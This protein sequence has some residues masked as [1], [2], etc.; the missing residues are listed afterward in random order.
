MKASPVVILTGPPGSGKTTV[1]RLLA[2][3][4][5]RSVHLESDM[6]FRWI[7]GGYVEPWLAESHE[8]NTLVMSV[9]A[10]VATAYSYA[11]YVTIVDGIL[12]PGWFLEPVVDKLRSGGLDVGI[13]ILRPPLDVCFARAASRRAEPLDEPAVIEQLWAGYS[14]LGDLEE[15]VIDN[16]SHDPDATTDAVLRRLGA[17][18]KDIDR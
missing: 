6:F 14:D 13:V 7:V 11:G 3:R 12:V 17:Q 8:Q 9:V 10:D 2:E 1:A 15:S 18:L 4:C 16:A 5:E